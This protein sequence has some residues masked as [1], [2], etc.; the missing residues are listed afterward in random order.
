MVNSISVKMTDVLN[1]FSNSITGHELFDYAES[2]INSM[3][4]EVYNV[5]AHIT[6]CYKKHRIHE[7][8]S[9]NDPMSDSDEDEDE[10]EIVDSQDTDDSDVV[11]VDAESTEDASYYFQSD[12]DDDL[13]FDT[14]G[15]CSVGSKILILIYPIKVNLTSLQ[16][17]FT[18]SG[19]LKHV[20]TSSDDNFN[21]IHVDCNLDCDEE[22]VPT[23]NDL[24]TFVQMGDIIEYRSSKHDVPRKG[25]IVAIGE[26]TSE[27]IIQVSD[28]TWLMRKVHHVKRLEIVRALE[29]KRLVNPSPKWKGL[30]KVV[31][32]P[33]YETVDD[34]DSD[35]GSAKSNETKEF[36][37]DETASSKEAKVPQN[38]SRSEKSYRE[39]TSCGVTGNDHYSKSKQVTRDEAYLNQRRDTTNYIRWA[40]EGSDYEKARSVINQLYLDSLSYGIV[41]SF[42]EKKPYDAPTFKEYKKQVAAMR[43]MIN[44]RARNEFKKL[45]ITTNVTFMD[46]PCFGERGRSNET[47]RARQTIEEMLKFEHK[48]RTLDLQTCSVCLENKLEFKEK[49]VCETCSKKNHSKSDYFLQNNLH[50]VWYERD[51]EGCIKMGDDGKPVVRYDVP[52]E[53][54]DLTMAEKLLI[55]RCSPFIPSMHIKDG[56]YGINGHCVCFPQDIDS[57][58]EELPQTQSNMVIFVRHISDHH[59]GKQQSR[60]YKVRKER[61]LAALRWL[62]I[63]HRGYH[64]ITISESNL[65]WIKN[66]SI[67]DVAERHTL[68]TKRSKRDVVADATETVSGNQCGTESNDD[69]IEVQ[70]IHPN[71]KS[72]TPNATQTKI[73]KDFVNIAKQTGQKDKVLNFPPIDH[74]KPLK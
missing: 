68:K 5:M 74:S 50:P 8:G 43:E 73:I 39:R 27:K 26:P 33:P 20:R 64:D 45:N 71:Y 61:V 18:T 23:S 55:R 44:Y 53:L 17:Y 3:R 16:I 13:S 19:D 22:A 67:Y 58:C 11:M 7:H 56:I 30:D 69:D 9:E 37:F 60:H 62:K 29:D 46:N 21:Y 40:N 31:V 42:Y 49:K 35:C 57:M 65:D 10:V 72:D 1:N 51:S 28:G 15:K 52:S 34:D 6:N 47:N 12:D 41:D 59:E 54:A 4:T 66:G 38:T 32:I 48:M 24:N 63:H 25:E 36:E 2:D 14:A 70:T